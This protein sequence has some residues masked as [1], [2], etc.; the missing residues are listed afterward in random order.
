MSQTQTPDWVDSTVTDRDTI[1]RLRQAG[2]SD[3]FITVLRT[4]T[5]DGIDRHSV[6]VETRKQLNGWDKD[7]SEIT[8]LAGD[9]YS[10]LWE[11]TD[12]EFRADKQNSAILRKAGLL[13][14]DEK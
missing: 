8:R 1:S 4:D 9:F 10:A 12:Y 6:R 3:D 14:I 13:P 11:G 7:P 5:P 2:A